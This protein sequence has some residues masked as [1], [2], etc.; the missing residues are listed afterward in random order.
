MELHFMFVLPGGPWTGPS[1]C[2]PHH[3]G[4]LLQA[5]DGGEWIGIAPH[6]LSFARAATGAGFPQLR[7]P[8]RDRCLLHTWGCRDVPRAGSADTAPHL[9]PS[10]SPIMVL[11]LDVWHLEP[12]ACPGVRMGDS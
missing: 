1:P 4:P 10:R 7:V 8:A 5:W 3:S 9:C 2:P 11:P 6:L 12:L